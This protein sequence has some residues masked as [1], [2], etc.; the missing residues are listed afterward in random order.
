[1]SALG[2]KRTFPDV[3]FTPKS[4]QVQCNS[5]CLLCA[6][7]GHSGDLLPRSPVNIFTVGVHGTKGQYLWKIYQSEMVHPDLEDRGPRKLMKL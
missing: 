2:Q 3:R 7:S 5:V 4:G 6:I 1:M